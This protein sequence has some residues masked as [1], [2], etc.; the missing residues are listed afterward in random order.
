ML[1]YQFLAFTIHGK[2]QKS[3]KNNKVKITAPARNEVIKL[4]DG[5]HSVSDTQDYFEY[6]IK[7][8]ETVPDNPSIRI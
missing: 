2:I 7:N 4:P 5:L 1:L 3:H 8:H 6:I